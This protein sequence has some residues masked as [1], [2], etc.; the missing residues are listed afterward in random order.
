MW[1][2]EMFR[3]EGKKRGKEPVFHLA[4]QQTF[5]RTIFPRGDGIPTREREIESEP[6]WKDHLHHHHR[7]LRRTVVYSI[8]PQD[9][10]R[11]VL[12][13]TTSTHPLRLASWPTIWLVGGREGVVASDSMLLW[14]TATS[15][16]VCLAE[17]S[18]DFLGH[19]SLEV[20][21]WWERRKWTRGKSVGKV[22]SKVRNVD[23]WFNGNNVFTQAWKTAL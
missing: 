11:N 8:S 23:F 5:R 6:C 14:F 19:F 7:L 16:F 12:Q 9:M 21:K 13:V 17:N 10:H 3:Q 22:V 4:G 20:A 1:R 15:D 2:K 18:I